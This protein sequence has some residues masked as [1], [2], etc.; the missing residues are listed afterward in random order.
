MNEYKAQL[1]GGGDVADMSAARLARLDWPEWESSASW[2]DEDS[3]E[4][5]QWAAERNGARAARVAMLLA[6]YA[7]AVLYGDQEREVAETMLRDMLSDAR[8]LVDAM[9]L[10]WEDVTSE[11]CYREE[12][13]GEP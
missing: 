6:E 10:Q 8:H 2:P 12:L 11:R 5:A 7:G 4:F 3:Q 13:H 1:P 9:G